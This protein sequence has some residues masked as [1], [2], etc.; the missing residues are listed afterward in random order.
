[1]EKLFSALL[2][3]LIKK[4]SVTKSVGLPR[5]RQQPAVITQW[6][7]GSYW[8]TPELLALYKLGFL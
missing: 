1:M 7:D 2:I 6:L 3:V 8:L 4:I 5:D